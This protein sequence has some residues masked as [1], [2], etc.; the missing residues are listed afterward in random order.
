MLSVLEGQKLPT[1]SFTAW[2]CISQRAVGSSRRGLA[3]ILIAY[4][5]LTTLP[6]RASY[7]CR[8]L[9]WRPVVLSQGRQLPLAAFPEVVSLLGCLSLGGG[10]AQVQEPSRRWSRQ[11]LGNIA[12]LPVLQLWLVLAPDVPFGNGPPPAKLFALSTRL[13]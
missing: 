5:K 10:P 8:T 13:A 12:V 3:T 11:Q 1:R 7:P 4:T 6:S 9:D 2:R